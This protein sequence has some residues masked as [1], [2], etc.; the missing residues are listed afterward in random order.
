MGK[1]RPTWDQYFLGQVKAVAERSTCNRGRSGAVIVVNERAVSTGYAGS[2]PGMPH[3]DEIGHQYRKMIDEKGKITNHCVRTIH[4][5]QNALVQAA[6]LGTSVKDGTMYSSMVPCYTCAKMILGAG[7]K[8]VVSLND[9]HASED[10]KTLFGQLGIG[11]VIVH[12]GVRKYKH[13]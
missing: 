9:Y 11:L 7:I 10:T 8:R 4:A 12:S 5:E 1:R 3:C 6:L 2:P 13:M